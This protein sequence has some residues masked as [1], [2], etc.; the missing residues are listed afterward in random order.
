[1]YPVQALTLARYR[2]VFNP[3]GA[4][5]DPTGA[6]LTLDLMFKYPNKVTPLKP[7]SDGVRVLAQLVEQR[8]LL[9]DM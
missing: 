2:Q 5:Y 4:K 6:E 1:M 9:V 7:S 8:R 3:S